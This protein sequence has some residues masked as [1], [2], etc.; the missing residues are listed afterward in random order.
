M[1]SSNMNKCPADLSDINNLINTTYANLKDNDIFG[2]GLL[3]YTHTYKKVQYKNFNIESVQCENKD[4]NNPCSV[5][6]GTPKCK[7]GSMI[8]VCIVYF[9]EH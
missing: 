3:R 2:L 6:E 7:D 9:L 4:P 8:Q 5:A 1:I